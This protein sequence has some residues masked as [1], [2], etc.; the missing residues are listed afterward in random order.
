MLLVPDMSAEHQQLADAIGVVDQKV[1][2]VQKDLEFHI[3]EGHSAFVPRL[4]IETWMEHNEQFHTTMID[5][6]EAL[7]TVV[8]GELKHTYD[9]EPYREGGL[10]DIINRLNNGGS[11]RISIPKGL[12]VAIITFMGTVLAALISTF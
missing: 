5:N 6:Q 4:E 12:W 2:Q 3:G 7:A 10:Q 1:G 9:G 11:I 8:L